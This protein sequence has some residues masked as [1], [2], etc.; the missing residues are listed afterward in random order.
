MILSLASLTMKVAIISC[1]YDKSFVQN[2]LLLEL[3]EDS[4]TS[5]VDF[6][7]HTVHVLAARWKTTQD[8]ESDMTGTNH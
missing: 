5:C 6:G 8:T 4:S 1:K 3:F 2:V 7:C